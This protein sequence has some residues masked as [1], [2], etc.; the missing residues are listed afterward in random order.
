MDYK[1]S[2]SVYGVYMSICDG[3][4]LVTVKIVLDVKLIICN[5]AR[6]E[7]RWL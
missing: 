2:A 1:G 6:L 7:S 5:I 3:M 4:Q